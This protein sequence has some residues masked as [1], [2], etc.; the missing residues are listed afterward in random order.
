MQNPSL[1]VTFD[2]THGA[3]L[4]WRSKHFPEIQDVLPR[5]AVRGKHTHKVWVVIDSG[6]G[7]PD[8]AEEN[9]NLVFFGNSNESPEMQNRIEQI[10]TPHGIDGF[11]LI[12][13]APRGSAEMLISLADDE[14]TITC[15]LQSPPA[16]PP[17]PVCFAEI[18]L[19]NIPVGPGAMQHSAH[20]YGGRTLP[21]HPIATAAPPGVVSVNGVIGL[22]LPLVYLFQPEAR[23]GL[24]MEFMLPHRPTAW[25]R[26]G[27]SDG[28]ATWAISW[29]LDRLLSPGES[30]DFSP[31]IRISSFSGTPVEQIRLWR[32]AAADRYKLV[33][34]PAPDWFRRCNI[35]EFNMNPENRDKGFTRLD[36]PKCRQMLFRWHD[37]GYNAIFAVSCNNV[38][39]NWLSPFDYDP[40]PAVGGIEAEKQFL[41]WA[42]EAGFHVFLWVTTVGIDRNAPEV[43]QHPDWFTHR[44]DGS[45][46]YAWDST[47]KTNF[48]GYAPDADPLS[49]GWRNWLKNQILRVVQRGYIG[50]FIDGLIPRASNHARCAWPGE[51]RNA[52]E[53]QTRDI[54]NY[55]RTLGP[56]LITFVEDE[57]PILQASVEMTMGRYTATMPFVQET[58]WEQ[59]TAGGPVITRSNPPRIKPEQARDYL[60]I[61]YASLLP[62]VLSNDVLEGYYS[63]ADQPWV[64]QSLLAG[65]VPKTH[66]Q[67]VDNP[68]TFRPLGDATEVPENEQSPEHRLRGHKAF[69]ALLKFCRDEPLIRTA[70][71]SIEAVT[72]ERN[73]EVVGLLRP[74]PRKC[75][76][77][78]LNFAGHDAQ[79]KISL[80]P[81][82]DI[83]QSQ[84]QGVDRIETAIWRVREIL[85]EFDEEHRATPGLLGNGLSIDLNI[86]RFAVRIFELHRR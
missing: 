76:M 44:P 63:D 36:D 56:D 58:S 10:T 84:R 18:S 81:P 37:L 11:R 74:G 69:I 33:P 26:R 61:R 32:D 54:A 47:A 29:S 48:V 3:R 80:A 43:A 21:V 66:S 15:S 39:L 52:V 57:S 75:I 9:L 64:A 8:W 38:G 51:G 25:T 82:T 70:P 5:L 50:V 46:F 59:G 68:A 2:E 86:R 72:I 45:L 49:S 16:G 31:G 53:D 71:L 77:A 67:Y 60:L 85:S 28:H 65:A 42:K 83:P 79:A 4:R 20:P 62:G 12:S 34:P 24:Q 30:H 7:P 78:I 13:T 73:A 14:L 27:S 23:R 1:H 22:A 19:N 41:A 17:L 6:E 55:V 35:I 40:A